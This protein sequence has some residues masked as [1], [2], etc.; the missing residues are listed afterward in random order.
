MPWRRQPVSKMAVEIIDCSFRYDVGVP[1]LRAVS[2]AVQAGTWAALIGQNGSGKTTLAKLCNGLL[3]PQR[4][5]VR[6]MG[7][8]TRHRSVGELARH[9]GYLFQNP[10]HQIFASS[11]REEIAFGLRNLGLSREEQEKRLGQTLSTFSLESYADQPPATLGYGLRRQ[12]TVASLFAL[13]PPILILDEPT[14]GLDPGLT[15]LLFERLRLLHRAGHTI[16]LITH[17]MKLV[18]AWAERVLVLH[19]GQL[20]ADGTPRAI[21]AQEELL[22]STSLSPPPITRLS[23]RLQPLGMQGDSTTVDDFYDEYVDLHPADESRRE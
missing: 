20:L 16:L 11:V 9:V 12:V 21:F 6:I 14:T 18:S 2:C 1:A 8:D 5:N 13:R 19:E 4:G 10:D 23:Q 3:R 22:A 15:E 7:E 17:D